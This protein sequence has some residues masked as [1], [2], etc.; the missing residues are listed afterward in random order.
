MAMPDTSGFLKRMHALEEFQRH[1]SF[2]YDALLDAFSE[3]YDV[4][5]E[6][7]FVASPSDPTRAYHRWRFEGY[8]VVPRTFEDAWAQHDVARAK[9]FLP[10]LGLGDTPQP[11]KRL[12]R[13]LLEV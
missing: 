7:E 10:P 4:S 3:E 13:H 12:L 8:G 11:K 2:R 1:T 5:P 9:E 6:K